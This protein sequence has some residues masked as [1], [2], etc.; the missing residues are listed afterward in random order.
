MTR[1]Q[2]SF[3]SFG[4]QDS[5]ILGLHHLPRTMHLPYLTKWLMR[6][7]RTGLSLITE[8]CKVSGFFKKAV[9]DGMLALV[10]KAMTAF[11]TAMTKQNQPNETTKND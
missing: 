5:V 1:S 2:M 9:A 7:L 8:L 6:G 10:N 3:R 11:E 4:Q